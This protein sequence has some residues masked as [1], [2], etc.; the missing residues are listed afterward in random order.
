MSALSVEPVT[1]FRV[2]RLTVPIP[3]VR[4]FQARYEKAVPNLPLDRVKEVVASGAPWSAMVEMIDAA[5]PHGFLIYFKND[6]HPVMLNAG[7]TA[8]CVAYLMGNH[9]IAE[10]MFRHDPRAMLYAPLRT[11]IWEGPAGHAWFTV[12]QPSTQFGS[13]G[14][15]EVE[16]VGE[17]LDRKLAL[18]LEELEVPLP[19]PLVAAAQA[20]SGPATWDPSSDPGMREPW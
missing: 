18:L 6:V 4:T 1:S 9:V 11:L 10:T 3:G 14:N 16:K 15:P 7:D 17:E 13:L 12:D 20:S 2:R 5:A 19:G 8:D